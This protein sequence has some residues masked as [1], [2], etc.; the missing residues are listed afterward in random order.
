MEA[1][2]FISDF[3]LCVSNSGSR[4]VK[5]EMLKMRKNISRGYLFSVNKQSF[6]NLV[7]KESLFLVAGR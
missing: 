6:D 2:I 3:R 7:P 5:S 1:S 4:K